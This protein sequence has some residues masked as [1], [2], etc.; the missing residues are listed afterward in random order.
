METS[1]DGMR[2]CLI[3]VLSGGLLFCN[4]HGDHMACKLLVIR[5]AQLFLER[6]Q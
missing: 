4:E 2:R 5:I 3:R 1:M 6:S